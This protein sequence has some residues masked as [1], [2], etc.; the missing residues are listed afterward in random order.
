MKGI[1]P[2][3]RFVLASFLWSFGANLVYFFLNFH[4]E[5]LGYTRAHIGYAQALL[6]LMGVV[7]A[8][9]LAYLIPRLGYLKSLYSA[10]FLAAGSGLLLGLGLLVFPALGGYG[11]A[12][13]LLQGAAAPLMA[14]L[15][16]PERWVALFSL[17][18]ALT[19]ASGFFSTLLAGLLS[20]WVGA[21]HVLLFALPFFLLAVP[22]ALGLPEGEGKTPRLWGRFGVWLRLLVPQVVIGFGAGL[23]IP[24]LNLYLKEKFGLTYGAT[25]LVFALSSLATG[26]AMLLQPL[27][28]HRVG[29]LKAIVLVQALSLPFLA[30]LAWAPWLPV[31]TF[32]LLVR[33]ALMNAAGPVYAALV[34]DYLP[35]EERPGF[36]LVESAL[37][38]LLFA[39][40]SALSGKLQAA[41]GL[42]AF[43]YLFGATLAL[44]ALGIALWPWAFGR[45]KA[46]YEA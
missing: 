6:L 21:R 23:V 46:L 31:V 45:L 2:A 33:G 4:L 8:L 38:S 10:F 42:P 39:L 3:Y 9:P 14:R 40:G 13:A 17:Q 5:A 7:S 36:F 37:W 35:E 11:L 15:V 25:G 1:S 44:Y 34:M 26:G 29:K 12:G 19:T 41:L 43:H 18:A 16:P 27:L 22:L 28:V 24:F 32:A 20:E 30:L